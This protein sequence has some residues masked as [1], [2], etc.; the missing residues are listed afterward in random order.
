MKKLSF[1]LLLLAFPLASFAQTPVF[2]CEVDGKPVW[3]DQPCKKKGKAVTVKRLQ[4]GT[5]G[6]NPASTP[7]NP[8]PK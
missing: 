1:V 2:R 6:G 5:P 3:S 4:S 7:K 8:P